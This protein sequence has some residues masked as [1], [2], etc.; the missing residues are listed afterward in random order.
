MIR[1]NVKRQGRWEVALK[2][3]AILSAIVAYCALT[4]CRSSYVPTEYEKEQKEIRKEIKYRD[5]VQVDS[6][7]VHDSVAVLVKGDTIRIDRWHDKYVEHLRVD[8]MKIMQYDT[9]YI[10]KRQTIVQQPTAFQ[11]FK[12]SAFWWLVI[13]LLSVVCLLLLSLKF[14]K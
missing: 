10:T 2:L 6:V 3:L 13:A 5:R 1:G 7:F 9:V 14:N 11:R 4:G 12:M 8:T